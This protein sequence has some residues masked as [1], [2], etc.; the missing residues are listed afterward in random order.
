MA[1]TNGISNVD[2]KQMEE[3]RQTVIEQELSA[4][5]WIAMQQKM[6]ATIAIHKM[7]DEYDE[8][9]N[10]NK[11]KLEEQR[12]QMNKMFKEMQEDMK[13]QGAEVIDPAVEELQKN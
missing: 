11:K 6:D 12:E 8:V 2:T 13:K 9:L 5:S 7:Q 1:K 4:R 3:M 10:F